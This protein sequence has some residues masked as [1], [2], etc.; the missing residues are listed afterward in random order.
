MSLAS[1]T[2]GPKGKRAAIKVRTAQA[3]V[4]GVFTS[5]F[6]KTREKAT[7]RTP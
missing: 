2:K 4:R 7:K 6:S 5:A 1:I 3:N